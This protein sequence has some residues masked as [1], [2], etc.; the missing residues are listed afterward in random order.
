[1]TGG[2]IQIASYGIHDIYL[3]GNPQIT[4]FKT[5]Y[6]RH[7]NFAMEYI[8]ER[9]NNE[10]DFGSTSSCIIS[11]AGDLL[12]RLYLKIVIPQVIINKNLYAKDINTNTDFLTLYNTFKA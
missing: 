10:S 11:K 5:V 9:F 7:C 4:F 8:E 12:H 6:R 1:M 3:I 2:L